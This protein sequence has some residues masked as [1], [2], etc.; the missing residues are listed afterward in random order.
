MHYIPKALVLLTSRPSQDNKE[1][2][3]EAI[4][5]GA[6]DCWAKPI[7]SSYAENIDVITQKL[8]EIFKLVCDGSE[9][10]SPIKEVAA[11]SKKFKENIKR[12]KFKPDIVLIAASTGGPLA[13][14]S[15]LAGLREDFPVPILIVQHISPHFTE[16]LTH[17][18][19]KKAHLT[20]KVAEEGETLAAGTAYVAPGGFHMKLNKRTIKLDDSPPI[21]KVRPAADVLFESVSVAY[22]E[23]KVLAVIL[24]GMGVDGEKGIARLKE[25]C[26][27][28]CLVQ[29]EETCVVYGM[30]RAVVDSGLADIVIDLDQIPAGIESLF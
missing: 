23:N 18:L 29:S 20:V 8:K 28:F 2:F 10:K 11:P 22:A 19:N 15:I 30:P 25:N 12:S 24:T 14:E 21:N 9:K 26:E 13:L 1:L 4:T 27:C 7:Y 16:S 5:K 17:N 3:A 6:F